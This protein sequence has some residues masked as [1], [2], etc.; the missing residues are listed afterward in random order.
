MPIE[1]ERSALS[2]CSLKV[3]KSEKYSLNANDIIIDTSKIDKKLADEQGGLGLSTFPCL[4]CT[5]SKDEHRERN[6][7]MQGFPINRSYAEGV[8]EGE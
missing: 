5:S 7:V 6:L 1:N 8:K 3:H 4:L 2:N